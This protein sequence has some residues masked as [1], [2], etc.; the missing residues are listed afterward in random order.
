M[1]SEWWTYRLSDF[2]LFTPRTYYRM[3]ERYNAAVWPAQIVASV[4][5]ATLL[6]L[7]FRRPS[8]LWRAAAALIGVAWV[9]VA[10]AFHVHRYAAINWAATYFAW[11]FV[12]EGILLL[13]FGLV[14]RRS[15]ETDPPRFVDRSNLA[16]VVLAVALYPL[17]GVLA[18]RAWT[19]VEVFG[20]APDPTAIAT[21][22]VLARAPGGVRAA[23]M[24]VPILWCGTSGATLYAIKAPDAFV[25][26]LAAGLALGSALWAMRAR[27]GRRRAQSV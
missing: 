18:G 5:G 22:G 26:L 6:W 10:F 21:L 11:A 1:T 16:L 20:V 14:P 12:V 8:S 3:F 15:V 23:L 9:W 7:L 4:L 2:L 27:Q 24:I 13:W 17:I 25:P 19:Q